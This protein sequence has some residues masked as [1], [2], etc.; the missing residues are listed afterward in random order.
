MTASHTAYPQPIDSTGPEVHT[1][2]A[3][4][5]DL[6]DARLDMTGGNLSP[7]PLASPTSPRPAGNIE[8]ASVIVRRTLAIPSGSS[9]ESSSSHGSGR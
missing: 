6:D 1:D 5:K 2:K 7:T 4:R 3:S 9:V 8:S